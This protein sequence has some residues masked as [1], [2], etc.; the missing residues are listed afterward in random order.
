MPVL[1][2]IRGLPGSGKSTLAQKLVGSDRHY[3]SDMFFT[4]STG[5]YNFDYTKLNDAHLWCL[6]SVSKALSS[7]KDIAV[8]N[9]FTRLIEY[10]P[11]IEIAIS[12][13][14]DYQVISLYSDRWNGIHNVPSS[15]YDR[16]LNRWES[17]TMIAKIFNSK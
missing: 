13:N 6:R 16:M 9:T 1:Y 4:S 8:S 5:E 2:I 15:V 17:H 14:Y 10:L 3:E 12:S 7:R 11:Y